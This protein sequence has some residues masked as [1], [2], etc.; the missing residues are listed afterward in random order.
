MN[1]KLIKSK[2]KNTFISI[3]KGLTDLI[4]KYKDL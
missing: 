2:L 1:N 3:D 4:L